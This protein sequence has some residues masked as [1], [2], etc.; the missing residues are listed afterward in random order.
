M[1][2]ATSAG[3]DAGRYDWA[4]YITLAGVRHLART[5]VLLVAANLAA[6]TGD[7]RAHSEKML[8]LVEAE[9]LARLTGVSAGGAGAI[10]SYQIGS[11]AVH[12]MATPE[13]YILR[14]KYRWEVWRAQNTSRIG[15][16]V[17]V[18]VLNAAD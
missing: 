4:A 7:A 1:A 10:E 3:Y 6:S 16:T 15:P 9:L 11:R 12:K 2:A 8:A 17:G 18:R 13:L 5:G 14:N